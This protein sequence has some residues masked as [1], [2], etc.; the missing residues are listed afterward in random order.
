MQNLAFSFFLNFLASFFSFLSLSY[1]YI[2]F[3]FVVGAI[4][5]WHQLSISCGSYIIAYGFLFYCLLPNYKSIQGMFLLL[6]L[7]LVKFAIL[8][9]YI[10]FCDKGTLLKAPEISKLS[11][12]PIIGIVPVKSGMY[13][14]WLW[15]ACHWY[16]TFWIRTF[17]FLRNF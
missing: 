4:I 15:L 6:F 13:L 14:S 17:S 12:V 3:S 1:I 2:F 5:K 7:P 9:T 16:R 10:V 11:S 8:Y